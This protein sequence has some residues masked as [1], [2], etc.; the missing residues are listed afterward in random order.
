MPVADGRRN[1]R[2]GAAFGVLVGVSQFGSGAG[3][4]DEESGVGA[5]A[6]FSEDEPGGRSARLVS[7]RACASHYG[8]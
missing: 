6:E 3:W 1:D 2:I 8:R 5:G 7:G 4:E